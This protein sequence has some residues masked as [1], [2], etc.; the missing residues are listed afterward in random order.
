MIFI[1]DIVRNWY[2][3]FC[4]YSAISKSPYFYIWI[5]FGLTIAILIIITAYYKLKELKIES[6]IENINNGLQYSETLEV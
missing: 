2:S 3:N 6:K 4:L 1:S 5:G